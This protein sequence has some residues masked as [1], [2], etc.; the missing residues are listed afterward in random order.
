M[1]EGRFFEE[2]GLPR[3]VAGQMIWPVVAAAGN[4]GIGALDRCAPLAG[5]LDLSPVLSKCLG[6]LI[7][8]LLCRRNR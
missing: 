6:L 3:G 1:N 7:L 5:V 4:A 2:G 8:N